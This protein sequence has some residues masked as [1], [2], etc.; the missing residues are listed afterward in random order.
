[1]RRIRRLLW[2]RW[3]VLLL[4][5]LAAIIALHVG[6]RRH[7]ELPLDLAHVFPVGE[8]IPQGAVLATTLATIVHHEL[9]D[10]FGWRPNDLVVWGPALWADNN[11]HRQLGIIEAVRV[12]LAVMMDDLTK[13]ASDAVDPNLGHADTAFQTDARRLW[14]PSAESRYD[15]GV[16]ALADYVRGLG[17]AL[18]TSKPI[19]QQ[20]DGLPHLLA[21]WSDL[22]G[23]AH[24]ELYRD[25]LRQQ[26][27]RSWEIDDLFYR[28]QGYAHVLAHCTRALEREYAQRL[29]AQPELAALFDQAATSLL[30]AATMKPFVIL[31]GAPD[32]VLA[33]HRRNLD[34]ALGDARQ[35]LE[36]I[37]HKVTP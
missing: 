22:L 26:P 33:N 6:Q 8:P 29:A 23:K 31:D 28:A 19:T 5:W 15:D 11:A 13:A 34:A 17:P 12:T 3:G 24:V 1:M 18:R 21:V 7:D 10:G 4:I 14:S 27:L 37:R 2:N 35:T 36:A 9:H 30:A 20:H 25:D 16:Q 32:G